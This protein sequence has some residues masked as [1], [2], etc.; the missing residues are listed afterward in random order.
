MKSEKEVEEELE[1]AR[2]E[3]RITAQGIGDYEQQS[4]ET[5]FGLGKDLGYWEGYEAALR[6]VLE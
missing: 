5:V 1:K 2:R 6:N 4:A 3:L